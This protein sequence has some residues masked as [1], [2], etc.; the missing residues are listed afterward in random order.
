[1]TLADLKSPP[2]WN[3]EM[4]KLVASSRSKPVVV[5][6]TGPKSSGKSTFG[7]LLTNQL[8][9][10]KLGKKQS[11]GV[12]VLDL[13]PGQPEYG[14][15][16]QIS[17]VHVTDP[18]LGPS[19]CSPHASLF[20]KVGTQVIRSHTLVSV[21]PASDPQLYVEAVADLLIHYRNRHAS[22]PLIVNTPGWVQ[23]TG[24]DILTSLIESIRLS[25]VLYMAFGPQDVIESLQGSFKSGKVI[26]LPSQTTQITARTAAHLRTMQTISY[27]HADAKS[28]IRAWNTEPLSAV[29]PWQVQFAGQNAG[30]LGV[31]CYDYQAPSDLLA[32]AING[33]LLAAVEIESALAFR[34]LALDEAENG[35]Q[36]SDSNMDVDLEEGQLPVRGRLA[37]AT[38]EGIPFIK[39]A[40][41][42]DPRYSQ[43]LGLVL[44]RGI[45]RESRVLQVLTPIPEE[46][47]EQIN[48][49]GGQIVLVSGKLDPPSWA[50]TE[51]LYYGQQSGA[52]DEDQGDEQMDIMDED[53]ALAGSEVGPA[54]GPT[55]WI[56]V[57]R[58]S[59]KR[60]VGSRVWRVRRD[61]GRTA[62]TGE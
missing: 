43:A 59:Q 3:R 25:H 11:S 6:V 34:D 61:L 7:K 46:R 23:G 55:P 54:G 31:L 50:Y 36:D 28:D 39:T 30:L 24:L 22:L 53:E 51:D 26:T 57:L 62:N 38:P 16:G 8:L 56:E 13:D 48:E 14:V 47:I 18:I 32:D 10:D 4:E 1:V 33:T 17:L 29:P 37:A 52:N 45:D 58:G 21:S 41:P 49:R 60:G 35:R 40:T 9:T 44:V 19:F 5:M 15:P 27:F 20:T 12:A 2:E 42:L